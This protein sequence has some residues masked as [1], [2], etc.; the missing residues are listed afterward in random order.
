M[1]GHHLC[2]KNPQ[3]CASA[4]CYSRT[5]SLSSHF[6][7]HSPGRGVSDFGALLLRGIDRQIGVTACFAAAVRD[8]RHPSSIAPPL[9]ALFAQRL[10]QMASGYADG[11]DA[12]SRR[13]APL[14]PL[15]GERVPLDP[16]QDFA[17]APT[18]SRLA[19]RVTRPALSRLPPAFV[20]HCLARAPEPPAAMGLDLAHS[21]DP[22]QGQQ[23]FPFSHHPSQRYGSVPRGIFAG[24]S[25]P[26]VTACLRPGKRPPGRANALLVVRLLASLRRPWPSTLSSC[27][28]PVLSRRQQCVRC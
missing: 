5:T 18:L 22:T 9:R 17:R 6:W 27:A 19:H 20:D 13:S 4:A 1:C 10:Y 14:F 2:R 3:R 7:G 15:R 24:T 16:T 23:A 8:K 12:H 28:A 21:A 26:L 11:H 25:H